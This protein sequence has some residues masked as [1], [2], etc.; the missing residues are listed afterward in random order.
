MPQFEPI[1]RKPCE[2][3]G[4]DQFP[5]LHG[6]SEDEI[7]EAVA[8]GKITQARALEWERLGGG[9]GKIPAR[10]DDK[11]KSPGFK[12][13]KQFEPTDRQRLFHAAMMLDEFVEAGFGG[14]RYGG[15]SFSIAWIAYE[16]CILFPGTCGAIFRQDSVDLVRS[17]QQSFKDWMALYQPAVKIYEHN[18]SPIYYEI[19]A[20]GPRKSRIY[21]MDTK[22]VSDTQSLNLHWAMID[23]ASETSYQFFLMLEAAVGRCVLPDGRRPAGKIGWGSNP[24]PGWCKREF[25]VGKSP[26]RIS[27]V[28]KFKDDEGKDSEQL[29]WR[30]FIPA[31][32]KD[33]KYADPLFEARIRATYPPEW[34]ARWLEGDWDAFEGQ[35]FPEFDKARHCVDYVLDPERTHGWFHVLAHDWGFT[36]PAAALMCS[37][38]YDGHWWF[39][40]G[41][42]Q[43]GWKPQQHAPVLR[44]MMEGLTVSVQVI[45][46]AAIDQLTGTSLQAIY[47]DMG[48]QFQGCT[49]RKNGPTGSIML[50]KQLLSEGRVHICPD[51]PDFIKEIQNAQWKP[52]P[53][54]QTN[55]KNQFEAMVDK[56]DH[57]LDAAF[58]A[59]EHWR[60]TGS[61]PDFSFKGQ[62]AIKIQEQYERD[63]DNK[64]EIDD[65]DKILTGSS[66]S[67]SN[68]DA[69]GG[70]CV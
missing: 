59:L 14:G 66:R 32:V 10:R 8:S 60:Q 22:T 52:L 17:T 61:E 69:S 42:Y 5:F 23:E 57:A 41:H 51:C 4:R 43:A 50:F 40:R 18:S 54:T 6:H 48:F 19:D 3:C 35:V 37:I 56:D 27:V 49:K 46:Y 24:G 39:W 11:D 36:N 38:D 9:S 13:L 2:I 12:S 29:S 16:F 45:D 62:I 44:G 47:N 70:F 33:N 67:G 21:W 26:G 30:F 68:F 7:R 1:D 64:L 20:G 53:P 31:W 28:L 58:M 25:P 63:F 55:Q 15:K 34:V 65:I